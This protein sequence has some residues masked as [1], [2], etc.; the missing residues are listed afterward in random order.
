M[1]RIAEDADVPVVDDDSYG[2]MLPDT[3]PLSSYTD[4]SYYL[5]G[6]SK[7]L[8]PSLR[9]GFLRAPAGM[10]DRLAAAIAGTVF[11]TSPLA[12]DLVVDWLESGLS[13]RIVSWKRE[14]VRTRQAAVR[15]LLGSADYLAHPGSPHGWLRLPE[16]WTS[17][18][19]VEQAALRGVHVSPADEFSVERDTPHAVRICVGPVPSRVLLEEAAA[20]LAKMLEEGPDAGAVV[21]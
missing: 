19:F 21:V 15:R 3:R 12:T 8:L 5:V 2:F 20:T 10:T 13:D 11:M 9:V 18:L 17:R 6:T 16:P 1:A 14:Q 4:D 7:P